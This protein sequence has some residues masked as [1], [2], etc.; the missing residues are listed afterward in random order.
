M[1]TEVHK[2]LLQGSK[3]SDCT[4]CGANYVSP[5]SACIPKEAATENR[6]LLH[7]ELRVIAQCIIENGD[8]DD[9]AD[10]LLAVFDVADIYA[11]HTAMLERLQR[12]L[13]QVRKS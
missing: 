10:L 2:F 4:R 9:G 11:S 7:A 5:P 3:Y 8:T 1:S 12:V 6:R 13:T